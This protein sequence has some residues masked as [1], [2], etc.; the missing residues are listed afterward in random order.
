MPNNAWLN[1]PVADIKASKDFF[2]TIGLPCKDGPGGLNTVMEI[3]DGK[4]TIVM[5][6]T[7]F[8]RS[9]IQGAAVADTAGSAEILIS[10]GADNPAEVD[11]IAG[12]V[13]AAGGRMITAP[14]SMGFMYGCV[15]ADLDGH[16]WNVV[17]MDWDKM[18]KPA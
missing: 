11:A 16:R 13:E 7:A 3:G 1:L 4:G 15:F 8:F 10:I 17:F 12:K 14:A 2:N 9:F 6:P 5:F 18:P